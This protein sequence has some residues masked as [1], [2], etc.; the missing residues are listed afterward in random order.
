MH[1]FHLDFKRR[2]E[3]E[4]EN[5]MYDTHDHERLKE[6]EEKVNMLLANTS[7]LIVFLSFFLSFFLFSSLSTHRRYSYR[8][9]KEMG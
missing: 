5:R 9:A 8:I 6:N 7:T 2:E 4:E 1:S 3:E